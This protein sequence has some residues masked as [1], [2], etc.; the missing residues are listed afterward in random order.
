MDISKVE[1]NGYTIYTKSNCGWCRRTKEML[2][3]AP[4]IN[5]DEYLEKDKDGFLNEMAKRIGREHRTFPMVFYDGGFIG[6]YEDTKNFI[7]FDITKDF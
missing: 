1:T 3:G 2:P 6:G 4:V 5:C 7:D